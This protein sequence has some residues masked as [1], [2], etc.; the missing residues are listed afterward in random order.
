MK[1]LLLFLALTAVATTASAQDWPQFLGPTADSKSTQKNLLREW[2]AEGPE[3]KWTT[4]VG[5]G[6][7]GP[8]VQDGKVYLLD[9]NH[10]KEEEEMMRCFDLQSGKE[11]WSYTY[12]APGNVQ[13]PGS[14]SVP[15]V[16]GKYVYSCG[17]SGHFYCF[18]TQTGKP[19]WNKN[20][21][22][23]YGG[24]KLPVWAISQCPLVYGDL[25]IVSSL[26]PQAGLLA[27]NKVS[28]ELVWKTDNLGP[29]SYTS[30]TIVKVNGEDHLSIVLS[31]TNSFMHPEAPVVKGCVIGFNPKTGEELWRFDN[32]QCMISC[33]PLT[34]AGDNKFLIVGGYERGSTMF[35]V[36][37][38][39]GKFTT[40]EIFTQNE[41][42]DQT[43][44]ALFID[45]HFY[46]QYGTN[47]RRDGLCCMD[48]Q[49]NVLWKTKRAPNFDKG[50]MI[51]ADGLILAT[52]GADALY[53]IE[54]SPEGYKQLAKADLL[55]SDVATEGRGNWAPIALAGDGL[56]LI[57]NHSE[58]KCV[59][60]TR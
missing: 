48:M 55:K 18:D 3:V 4:N 16:D 34:E 20:I 14:R 37:K 17:H 56:L 36:V 32:W 6:Y 60:V 33:A 12:S 29:E 59:K 44:P 38:D 49:G 39:G 7:G 24:T 26:A 8:V 21:W 42:G 58:M 57:R 43:K 30:P 53:L 45:G 1:K 35:Q 46:A 19:V 10:E 5:I 25:V 41:F 13:Y 15:T 2:P 40:K 47:N 11:L 22:T 54:P 51:L 9:R 31:S 28:G 23:E 52:D 50:S 27:Y